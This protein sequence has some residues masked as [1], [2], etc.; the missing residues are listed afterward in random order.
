MAET[1]GTV[2]GRGRLRLCVD[3]SMR[4]PTT[5][6]PH[7]LKRPSFRLAVLLLVVA[8]AAFAA[9]AGGA[10]AKTSCGEKVIDDWYGSKTGQLSHTYP[11]HC[12]RD[13]L[14]DHQGPYRSRRLLERASGHPLRDAAGDRAAATGGGPPDADV[15]SICT[16]DAL[17]SW[18]GGPDAKNGGHAPTSVVRRAAQLATARPSGPIVDILHGSS[19]VVRPAARDRARRRSPR[20]CSSLGSAA[21]VARRRQLRRQTLRPQAE[22]GPQN[23][24][25]PRPPPRYRCTS[26]TAIAPSPTAEATRL[27]EPS[28]ASPAKK[29]PGWL[30]SRKNGGAV[31]LPVAAEVGA[32]DDEALRDR[33]GARTGQLAVDGV[34]PMRMKSASAGSSSSS[35]A[36]LDHDPLELPVAAAPARCGC[37]CGTVIAEL[38]EQRS[39]RYW[40]ICSSSVSPRTSSVT[41]RACAARCSAAWPA[42]FAPPTTKT[43][44]PR[45]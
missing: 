11:L 20:S 37:R 16:A 17:P 30:D 4:T 36:R 35:P 3:S 45:W 32:G 42:E 41:E 24:L 23:P 18:H 27:T 12:Y 31:E 7:L 1:G 25:A 8:A 14:S 43:S 10:A 21:Y 33:A 2:R 28:R 44:P 26:C 15:T 22:S 29:N 40:D 5:P 34:P 39:T 38:P 19:A 13:A 6:R 9:T